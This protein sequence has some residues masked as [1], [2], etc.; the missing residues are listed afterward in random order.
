MVGTEEARK[1][2][3]SRAR[4]GREGVETGGRDGRREEVRLRPKAVRRRAAGQRRAVETRGER[5]DRRAR[6]K[7]RNPKERVCR[8]EPLVVA[9]TAWAG[10][11]GGEMEGQSA[12]EEEEE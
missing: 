7:T 10:G 5:A 4:E 1:L 2:S 9:A 3:L 6:L 8:N 11:E 12:P